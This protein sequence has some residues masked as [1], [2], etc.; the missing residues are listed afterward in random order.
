MLVQH[1]QKRMLESDTLTPKS[2]QR[3]MF[4]TAVGL[5][6][7]YAISNHFD[8]EAHRGVEELSPMKPACGFSRESFQMNSP[9][10]RLALLLRQFPES[11]QPLFPQLLLVHGMEDST[12][13]FTAT[14]DAAAAFRSC[15]VERCDELYIGQ[16]GHQETIMHFMFG[17]KTKDAV[18][19]WL[20]DR[21]ASGEETVQLVASSKL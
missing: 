14:S 9:G 4:D 7:P 11:G 18:L 2:N 15:G 10:T 20:Q 13:P 21:A 3:P 17:G 12:V 1:I 5:S 6:G 16:T 8:F 19:K